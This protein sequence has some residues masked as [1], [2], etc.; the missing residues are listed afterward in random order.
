MLGTSMERP[1]LTKN[2][3]T[4]IRRCTQI[5]V[6]ARGS[7][8]CWGTTLQ[9]RTSRVTFPTRSLD[10]FNSP[11]PTSRTMVQGSTQPLTY[12]VLGTFLGG[13]GRPARGA[14]LTANCEPIVY[15]MWEPR[16]LKTYGSPWPITGIALPRFWLHIFSQIIS[17]W[18][19]IPHWP[20]IFFHCR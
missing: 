16:R 20:S 19:F 7:V 15:K 13:K 14:D 11:N 8:I 3:N 18:F 17:S 5:L 12:W 6:G 9:A 4:K 1:L 2:L 10:F